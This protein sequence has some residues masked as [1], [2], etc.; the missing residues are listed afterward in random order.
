ML[1]LI[2]AGA[3]TILIAEFFYVDDPSGT[4]LVSLF[5]LTYIAWA[6]LGVA[7]GYVLFDLVARLRE[8]QRPACGCGRSRQ[9][10][11]SPPPPAAPRRDTQPHPPVLCRR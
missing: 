11:L 9:P 3:T 10:W 1:L 5:K 6:L 4:R 8:L 2:A 7:A